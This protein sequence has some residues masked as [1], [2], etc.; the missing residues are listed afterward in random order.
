M[1][2]FTIALFGYYGGWFAFLSAYNDFNFRFDFILQFKEMSYLVT[3]FGLD[4][5]GD[6]HIGCIVIDN[7]AA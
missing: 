5:F 4:P 1:T 7:I 6:K 3:V 2:F